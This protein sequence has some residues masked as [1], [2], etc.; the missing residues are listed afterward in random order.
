MNVDDFKRLFEIPF[1]QLKHFPKEDSVCT[2]IMDRWWK[3]STSE[4][5]DYC[6]NFAKGLLAMGIKE[7]ETIAVVSK[8]NRTEWNIIDIG[9]QMSGAILVPLYPNLSESDY[10]YIF[11]EAEIKFCF[12]ADEELYNK[13]KN[14]ANQIPTL[15]EIYTM[16]R[17]PSVKN[18]FEVIQLGEKQSDDALNTSIESIKEEDLATIIYTSG[19]TGLPKGVMLSHK[20]IV[21]NVKASKIKLPD[22]ID[23]TC[24][25]LSFLPLCHIFERMIFYFY[26]ANGIS[27]YYA[28]SL[29]TIGEDAK[30]V[31]PH[32]MTVVPRLLEKVYGKIMEKGNELT[33]FKKKLF[34][35]SVQLGLRWQPD[36]KNGFW[37]NIK[38]GLARKLVFK[39]WQEALG[40]NIRVL[41]AGGAALP[42]HLARIFNAAGL[43]TVE[44]YGLTETSPV[45]AVNELRPGK[46]RIG[47]VGTPI[48]GVSVKIAEDGEILVKGPN[49]MLGYYKKPDETA[50]VFT[51][52]GYF[53]TGD[54]GVL[55]DGFL[56]I[57]DRKKE[58]FKTSGGKY[59]TPQPIENKLKESPFV[60]M[61]CVIGEG[62]HFPA[63]LI[64]PNYE[65]L[66]KWASQNNIPYDSIQSLLSH[67]EIIKLY[68]SIVDSVNANLGQW[69][70][71]KKFHLLEQPFT[72]E[73]EELTPTLKLK[74]RNILI[75]Y[76][77]IIE[78][79]YRE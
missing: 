25:A 49:V 74:R 19:T 9:T 75:H 68:Q 11:K 72:I 50:K 43:P 63:A 79:I 37:Y 20:N 26:M 4:F 48:P 47:T 2:K 45:I 59:I 69:E 78:K 23:S 28:R 77:D 18:W 8:N 10:I 57:T 24:R 53:A 64:V 76:A 27:I 52:D 54:I 7:G 55:E 5:I 29:D 33:G 31:R 58:M 42:P 40:G 35:W 73:K 3:L 44:G 13:V 14:F 6:K 61:A 66:K 38:L 15:K 67:P 17:V 62:R 1:Y 56:K 65:Y 22:N 70:K 39:K 21:S 60:E 46:M 16:D 12:C 30:D 71:I 41:V 34:N 51:P 36:N 32:I